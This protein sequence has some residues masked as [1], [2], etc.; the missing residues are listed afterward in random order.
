MLFNTLVGVMFHMT[1]IGKTDKWTEFKKNKQ[2][3]K[4]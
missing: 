4:F 3:K 2:R 1:D